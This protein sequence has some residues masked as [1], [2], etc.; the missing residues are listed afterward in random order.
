M[1]FALAVLSAIS[2]RLVRRGIGGK[3]NV[4]LFVVFDAALLAYLLIGPAPFFVE[5]WTPQLKLRFLH[6][7]PLGIFLTSMAFSYSP[8]VVIWTATVVAAAW[9]VGVLWV[10]GLPDT[11]IENSRT[12]MDS[13]ASP[14]Q[15]IR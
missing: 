15:A 12:A 6:F 8:G 11:K 9:S 5:G 4:A 2:Y 10:L 14:V 1:I 3:W 7:L 13:G